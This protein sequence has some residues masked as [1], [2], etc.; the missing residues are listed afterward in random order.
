MPEGSSTMAAAAQPTLPPDV[1]A[2]LDEA[3]RRIVDIAGPQ[4]VILFGS[5]AEGTANED[6]DIDLLVVAET[7]SW[8][9]LTVDLRRAIR[10]I[11]SPL[12]SD[13]LVYPPESWERDRQV[14]GFVAREAVRKGVRLY[15]ATS[16]HRSPVPST[17]SWARMRRGHRYPR[18]SRQPQGVG[19]ADPPW[20]GGS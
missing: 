2:K 6:S 3:V 16:S 4:L 1:A 12:R 10:P 17:P 8:H 5:Y 9:R 7:E 15:E 18:P 11:L 14:L 13:L 19:M 20:V